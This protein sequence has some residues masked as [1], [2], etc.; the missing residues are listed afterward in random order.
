MKIAPFLLER[1]F[2]SHEFS[3]HYLLSC[4][5]CEPLSMADLL[6]MA[7]PES[8]NMWEHLRLGYTDS[9]GHPLLREEIAKT[10]DGIEAE[11]VLV[12]APEEGIFLY[13]NSLLERGDHV[14]GVY[15][16]YQ[17]LYE[18]ARAIGCDVSFWEPREENGWC[19]DVEDLERKIRP[20][21]RLVVVNFPH[22][23]TGCILPARTFR[24]LLDIVKRR[25]IRLLSDEM[26][27]LLELREETTLPA[28]CG[29][30][31]KACSL[32]GLSKV[33]GL[34]GLRI[35][36]VATRDGELLDRM[37][38]MRDYTTICTSAPGEI[39]AIVAM[40]NGGHIVRRQIARARRNVAVLD[41]FFARYC[42][43]FRWNRP[44]GGSVCFPGIP[45]VE[46][47]AVFCG[48]L[49]EETG[50]MLLPSR[51]LHAGDHHVRIGFGRENLPEVIDR[52]SE[53]LNRRFRRTPCGQPPP[54]GR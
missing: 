37:R 29:L 51:E 53:Y 48:R 11:D 8:R 39:L 4:S 42:D 26:Y 35:G 5:D 41:S 38:G 24:D 43:L 36:W 45:A 19:F 2:A 52:F 7:D 13:M 6:A 46:D 28:A 47:T 22:N 9:R 21:T 34:P 30:Y 25:G 49:L 12:T 40:R 54:A 32:S 3:A 33:Y 10:Y 50:I 27:R 15:P 23:P 1:Y 44:E 14:V 16:A 17:S 31:D 18:I 20:D